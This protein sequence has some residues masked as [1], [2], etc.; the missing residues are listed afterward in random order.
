MSSTD[1]LD[2]EYTCLMI[3]AQGESLAAIG[4]WEKACCSLVEKGLAI[5]HDKF[6]HSITDAGRQACGEREQADDDALR[7]LVPQIKIAQDSARGHVEA[8]AQHLA[9]AAL[10]SAPVTGDAPE[11]ALVAWNLEVL[12]RARE[13]LRQ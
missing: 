9:R 5:R 1:L 12:K 11:T 10:A 7:R 4:R 2:D 6:N 3:M 8:A 13:L